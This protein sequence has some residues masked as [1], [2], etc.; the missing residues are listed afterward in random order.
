MKDHPL[1]LN[2]R[3]LGKSLLAYRQML[4]GEPKTYL[5]A[6]W[7]GRRAE[8]KRLRQHREVEPIALAGT[9]AHDQLAL[10][11]QQSALC[12]QLAQW[13]E[14]LVATPALTSLMHTTKGKPAYTLAIELKRHHPSISIQFGSF[15]HRWEDIDT[16]D[17]SFYDLET[18]VRAAVEDTKPRRR[19][20]L[21]RLGFFSRSQT[22]TA[23]IPVLEALQML[24]R[25]T[26]QRS[27]MVVRSFPPRNAERPLPLHTTA[28]TTALR[29]AW[30]AFLAIP[31]PSFEHL[32]SLS[33][34]PITSVVL[35]SHS[36][37]DTRA[38]IHSKT[39]R[40]VG[41]IR[42]ISIPRWEH[43]RSES[44]ALEAIGD[45]WL[46]FLR[47]AY[48]LA[49]V[50][51][52]RKLHH[53]ASEHSAVVWDA[54]HEWINQVSFWNLPCPDPIAFVQRLSGVPATPRLWTTP[55]RE[56]VVRAPNPAVARILLGTNETVNCI[57]SV[58]PY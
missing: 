30:D 39:E 18:F 20:T 23:S 53:A 9:S 25:G 3:H 14:A 8:I 13:G 52:H 58:L 4:M 43:G 40:G 57:E 50:L 17:R 55:D 29:A 22:C 24:Q 34:K 7:D 16:P 41:W 48:A 5:I 44:P 1:V 45:A 46:A 15:G 54:N 19:R 28:D 21:S 26:S 37:N 38:E 49:P 35:R 33:D 10:A 36:W 47:E 11:H 51:D 31:R 12:T 42:K 32:S 27:A 56:R 6:R 2:T